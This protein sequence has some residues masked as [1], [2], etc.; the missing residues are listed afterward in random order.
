MPLCRTR[1]DL[2]PQKYDVCWN[3][4]IDKEFHVSQQRLPPPVNHHPSAITKADELDILRH[5]KKLGTFTLYD[6]D[7][8]LGYEYGMSALLRLASGWVRENRLLRLPR[9]N[10]EKQRY[11]YQTKEPNGQANLFEGVR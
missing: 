11:Q 3:G 6:L 2:R 10:G 7:V 9:G 8:A 5:M 4:T 1:D